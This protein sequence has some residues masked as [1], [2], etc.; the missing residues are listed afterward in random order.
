MT[1]AVHGLR[2]VLAG[3]LVL[4]L[5][6]VAGCG[7]DGTSASTAATSGSGS[8][9]IDRSNSPTIAGIPSTTA[10]V[11]QPYSFQPTTAN[12]SGSVRFTVDHLPAWASFNASTGKLSGTPSSSQVGDYG[13]ITINLVANNATV[14]L[15]AFT[16]TVATSGSSGNSV[17]LSWQPPTENSDGST[18]SDL[19][20]YKVH[21]G[22]T[23][24]AYAKTIEVSNPGLTT[25]V[26][27]NLPTGN[28]FFAVTAYNASGY[29]SSLSGEVSTQVD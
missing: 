9:V 26:V 4:G 28:Y 8:A 21:Y 17:T 6:T 20:G 24:R 13:G 3:G 25:Y 10:V 19:K 29:E 7:A 14:A 5:A 27:D 23:S 16:I 11:G 15:P 12:T 1:R 2:S 22:S 18:I